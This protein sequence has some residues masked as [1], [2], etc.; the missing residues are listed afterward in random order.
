MASRLGIVLPTSFSE[1]FGVEGLDLLLRAQAG[2]FDRGKYLELRR[3]A[4]EALSRVS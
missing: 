2:T 1:T 3:I 4:R